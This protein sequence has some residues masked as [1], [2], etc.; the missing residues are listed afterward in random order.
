MNGI[1]S[2]I[3]NTPHA[4]H[5]LLMVA[6]DLKK[7]M[8]EELASGS[9]TAAQVILKWLIQ[10]GLSIIP[11]TS[12]LDRLA[13]NSAVKL[14]AIPDLDDAH[15]EIVAH[16]VEAMLSGTDLEVDVFVTVTFHAK[17]QD[18]F[19]YFIMGEDNETQLSYIAKGDSFE[20]QTHPHHTFRLYHAYNPD[21]YHTYTVEGTYGEHQHIH[22]EL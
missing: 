20:E 17:N 21:V 11:R 10:F 4:H 3:F 5:H 13:E 2:S 16:A 19:L 18:M 9:V 8:P 22:V 6:N 12:N 15:L 14:A 7:G 1:L